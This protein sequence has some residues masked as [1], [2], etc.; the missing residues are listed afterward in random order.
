MDG[1]D[2]AEQVLKLIAN[3]FG[4]VPRDPIAM[5]E[6][7]VHD[8]GMD[9]LDVA[10]LVVRLET[11]FEIEIPHDELDGVNTVQDVIDSVRK[12]YRR[13]AKMK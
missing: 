12:E 1:P 11:E 8:W 10:D 13:L 9:S 4:H 7:L 3:T 2:M 6:S 5:S